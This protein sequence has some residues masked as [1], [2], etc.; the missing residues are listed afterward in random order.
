MRTTVTPVSWCHGAAAVVAGVTRGM[1]RAS[2]RGMNRAPLFPP[3][4]NGVVIDLERV[5]LGP[6]SRA[7]RVRQAQRRERIERSTSGTLVP[8]EQCGRAYCLTGDFL[9]RRCRSTRP[10]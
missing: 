5:P 7:V 8:C 6:S 10:L 9:C 3:T 4:L 1:G 2:S